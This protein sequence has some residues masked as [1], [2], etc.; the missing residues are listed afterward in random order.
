MIAGFAFQEWD[1]R[2]FPVTRNERFYEC[3]EHS[4]VDIT[5]HLQ[6][7]RRTLYYFANLILPCVLIGTKF[8]VP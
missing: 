5:F 6:I 2:G 4:Y 3:C 1:L 7:R 8:W